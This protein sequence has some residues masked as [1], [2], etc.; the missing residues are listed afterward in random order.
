MA[1]ATLTS[2]VGTTWHTLLLSFQGATITVSYDGVQQISVTDN[3][4][5]SVAPFA[6][7][8]IC[9]EMSAYP[10]AYTM[11]LDNVA[12]SVTGTLPAPPSALHVLSSSP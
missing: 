8:G 10:A 6:S 4:F 11:S 1:T 5:G 2:G 12:V 7:G 3:N 9:A